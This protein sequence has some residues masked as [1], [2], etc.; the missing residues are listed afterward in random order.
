[1]KMN[2]EL[3]QIRE[4]EL[5]DCVFRGSRQRTRAIRAETRRHVVLNLVVLSTLMIM[6]LL[7]A[8]AQSATSQKQEA[9]T[10]RGT[11]VDSSNKLVSDATVELKGQGL[12][13]AMEAKTNST[14]ALC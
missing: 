8:S 5:S 6:I 13:R 3:T 2:K 4:I 9:G 1:M 10:I 7:N 11:V 14:G 12:T